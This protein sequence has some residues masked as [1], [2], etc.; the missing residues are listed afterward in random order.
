MKRNYF[1]VLLGFLLILSACGK[2]SKDQYDYT[3]RP[4]SQEE[5]WGYVDQKGKFVINPQF[6]SASFF[7]DGLALVKSPDDKF[8]YINKK[9]EYVINPQFVSATEFT[10][11][12]AFATLPEG[13]PALINKKGEVVKEFKEYSAVYGY[14]DGIALFSQGKKFGFLNADGEEVIPATYT[15]I[16]E[17]HEGLAV[18]AQP[19]KDDSLDFEYGYIN[20]KGEVVINPQFESAQNFS[21]GLA[22]ITSGGEDG[23]IDKTGTIVINP[24][25]ES[26][27]SFSEGLAVIQQGDWFGYI[28]KEGKIVINPQFD[29]A[30]SFSEGLAAYKSGEN[31]GYID[32]K[33]KIIINPQFSYVESFKRG[34]ATYGQGSKYGFINKKGEIIANAQFDMVMPVAGGELYFYGTFHVAR[35]DF[36]DYDAILNYLMAGYTNGAVG[37]FT[38]TATLADVV[39]KEGDS[40]DTYSV[41]ETYGLENYAFEEF[42]DNEAVYINSNCYYFDGEPFETEYDY[43]NYEAIKI[44]NKEV[45]LVALSKEI[46]IYSEGDGNSRLTSVKQKLAEQIRKTYKTQDF[47]FDAERT[48]EKYA[49]IISEIREE[50]SEVI[51]MQNQQFRFYISNDKYALIFVAEIIRNPDNSPSDSFDFDSYYESLYDRYGY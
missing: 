31:Y 28:N 44:W 37:G 51:C 38:V 11:G 33:G 17:F 29:E 41:K 7:S 27:Q 10:N 9:G 34:F 45:N 25:F 2:K 39:Q 42:P 8:G 48:K 19:K 18:I 47:K 16:G 5:R 12:K 13:A 50:D 3:L 36:F 22:V 32:K 14:Q 26:A 23:F 20:K 6:K 30:Y 24:Q 21:E 40:L 46:S 49:Y 43:D 15:Y 4:A 1:I 35:S